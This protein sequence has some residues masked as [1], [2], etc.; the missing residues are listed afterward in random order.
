TPVRGAGA[1]LE[2]LLDLVERGAVAAGARERDR[3]VVFG[4]LELD[5]V[6][7]RGV[8]RRLDDRVQRDRGVGERAV[9]EQ[10]LAGGELALERLEVAALDVDQLHRL[11]LRE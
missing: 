11:E 8:A 3:E 7:E 2:D 9:A 1:A 4:V 6:G 5:E 10:A